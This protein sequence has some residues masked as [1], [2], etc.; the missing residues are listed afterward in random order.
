MLILSTITEA[1]MPNPDCPA[2]HGTGVIR[3]YD[4]IGLVDEFACDLCNPDDDDDR[5]P[6][7]PGDDRY[8]YP[9]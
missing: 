7:A 9:K 5:E 1:S 8:Y 6:I 2:C 4:H 3:T